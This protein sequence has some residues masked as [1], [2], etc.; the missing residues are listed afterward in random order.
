MA[1]RQYVGARYV[2]IFDGDWDNTK[3]YDPLVI[4]SYLGNSYTSRTFVPHGTAITDETY[5]ALTGNYNAQVE[6]YREEVAEMKLKLNG[7]FIT[8]DDFEG[9]DTQKLQSA[10]DALSTSAGTILINRKYTISD[11]IVINNRTDTTMAEICLMGSNIESIIDLQTHAFVAGDGNYYDYGGIVF[12]NVALTGTNICFISDKLIRIKAINCTFTNF[13]KILA[14]DSSYIQQYKF[15][16]CSFYNIEHS[17][18]YIAHDLYDVHF[19]ACSCEK[20]ARFILQTNADDHALFNLNVAYSCIES[21]INAAIT[22]CSG[23]SISITDCFFEANLVDIDMSNGELLKGVCIRNNTADERTVD[24]Y[25]I[26]MPASTEKLLGEI[27]NN[28]IRGAGGFMHFE[29]TSESTCK[30]NLHDNIFNNKYV[31]ANRPKFAYTNIN[32]PMVFEQTSVTA[33]N[34]TFSAGDTWELC[35]ITVTVPANCFYEIIL[36]QTYS[37]NQPTG[38]GLAAGTNEWDIFASSDG[39][40][41]RHFGINRSSS[42]T[43]FKVFAKCWGA[44]TNPIGATIWSCP[45]YTQTTE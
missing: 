4:V 15:I 36:T 2:P 16:A 31:G 35:E 7:A 39:G 30:V 33:V 12:N 37:G 3:D 43:T 19:I 8:P 42:E 17:V 28:T 26:S 24:D 18:L 34:H 11:D 29:T 27:C 6:A 41:L 40:R 14:T 9:T 25:M 1:T 5:W 23:Y 21:C 38:I 13:N 45:C 44:A 20:S 22:L 10:F 32:T